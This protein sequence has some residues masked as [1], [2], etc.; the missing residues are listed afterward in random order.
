MILRLVLRTTLASSGASWEVI[1]AK[2][3]VC[4]CLSG[5]LDDVPSNLLAPFSVAQFLFSF[6]GFL[7]FSV[8]FLGVTLSFSADLPS[9][10]T[11]DLGHNAKRIS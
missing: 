4:Q 6:F 7:F 9:L 5:F 1:A 10:K 3:K 11:L 8:V 2:V